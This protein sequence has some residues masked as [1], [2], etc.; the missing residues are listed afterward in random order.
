MRY[1][2][3]F[4][5][6]FQ[7]VFQNRGRSF[8][9]FLLGLINPVLQL[10]FWSGAIAQDSGTGAYWSFSEM[11][12]YYLLVTIATSFLVVH[13]EQ[14]VAFLDIKEGKLTK[15]LLQPFSYF[16]SKFMEEFPWRVTQGAFGLVAFMLFIAF[17]NISISLISTPSQIFLAVI[18]CL[19]A[20]AIS[21]TLKMVLGLLAL[22]TT[23]FWG[24]LSIE[25][26][27]FLI[28][29]GFVMPLTYYPPLLEK[30][31]YVLPLAYIVYFPVIAVQGNLTAS[32]MYHTI[33]IQ[34][35]W[36]GLLY[37]LYQFVWHRGVKKYTG[38]GQ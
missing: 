38:V 12:S 19:L 10:L 21:Y 7:D 37:V 1:V 4:A 22:W 18:I 30:I 15:F 11:A 34:I 23:D 3:M 32:A 17:T 20:L 9:Y 35:L 2:R 33:L 28:F 25:E 29:G 26:V 6:H 14:D 16:I 5:L 27:V 24:I 36:L 13:I 8:I 31:S